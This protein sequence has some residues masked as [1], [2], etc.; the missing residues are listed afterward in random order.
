MKMR[1]S[2]ATAAVCLM[3]VAVAA[4]DPPKPFVAGSI[5]RLARTATALS[6][7][8][9]EVGRGTGEMTLEPHPGVFVTNT[10]AEDEAPLPQAV[11]WSPWGIE[12]P[13]TS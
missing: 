7:A 12:V 4:Q 6:C 9:H 10:T 5:P 8:T 11:M 1:I 13:G 3:S 2:L